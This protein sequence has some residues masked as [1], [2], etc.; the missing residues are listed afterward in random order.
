M[1]KKKKSHNSVLLVLINNEMQMQKIVCYIVTFI[2]KY[3]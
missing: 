3:L 2:Y 1:D